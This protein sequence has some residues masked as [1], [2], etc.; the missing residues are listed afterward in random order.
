MH[1]NRKHT[2][3]LLL[4]F[5]LLPFWSS[6]QSVTTV[7]P[8]EQLDIVIDQWTAKDGL[9][10]ITG[11]YVR[12]LV[13]DR[14]GF[15]WTH[16]NHS[17]VR[18]DG[19]HFKEYPVRSNFEGRVW[20]VE[21]DL[22]GNLWVVVSFEDEFSIQVFNPREERFYSLEAYLGSTAG[23]GNEF[24]KIHLKV[25]SIGKEI[26]LIND[27][28]GQIWKYDGQLR[29]I[30]EDEE[31]ELASYLPGPDGLF[32]KTPY[33]QQK[34]DSLFLVDA[35]GNP[36]Q[37]FPN[38]KKGSYH[39]ID[40]NYQLWSVDTS[41]DNQNQSLYLKEIVRP[42]GSKNT[43]AVLTAIYSG[44]MNTTF[45]N[46]SRSGYTLYGNNAKMMLLQK[47]QVII[48]DI[49]PFLTKI[50][51]HSYHSIPYSIKMIS[52]G[53]FWMTSNGAL[54][55][56]SFRKKNFTSFLKG[57]SIRHI[58]PFGE[59]QKLLINSYELPPVVIDRQQ[60][61]QQY[62]NV[63][64]EKNFYSGYK[65]GN[66]IWLGSLENTFSQYNLTTGVN[67]LHQLDTRNE[68]DLQPRALH[69]LTDST[70]LFCSD[71]GIHIYNYKNKQ[72]Q[73]LL[74]GTLAYWIH[75]DQKGDLWA[76]TGKGVYN[77]ST[78]QF[79]LDLLN[80]SPLEVKH[81]YEAP[82]GDFWLSSNQGLIHWKPFRKDYQ[83]ISTKDGLCNNTVHAAYPDQRGVL[84]LSTDNGI[85]AFDPK[86][87]RIQNFFDTDGL[88]D[89]EQNYL[90][91]CATA[92]GQLLF[93]GVSGITAFYPDNI[94]L[95]EDSLY[96]DIYIGKATFFD[97]D[98]QPLETL[99]ADSTERYVWKIPAFSRQISF[100]VAFP[101]FDGQKKVF[102]W[103]IPG[104]FNTWNDIKENEITLNGLPAGEY[105]LEVRG[106]LINNPDHVLTK[107][108]AIH[109][110]T[111]FY[112]QSWF[113][114]ACLLLLISSGWFYYKKQVKQISAAA[115]VLENLVE[116]RTKEVLQQKMLIEKQNH[117][118]EEI[119]Q[120]KNQLFNNISHEFR[121]PLSL[122]SGNSDQLLSQPNVP[123]WVQQPALNIKKH[124]TS[125]AEM[126]DEILSLQRIDEGV[127]SL[128][129]EAMDWTKLIKQQFSLF[130][131]LAQ[132][133]QLI[134]QLEIVPDQACIVAIN[135]K[136]VTRILQNLISNAIKYTPDR[137]QIVVRT[138]IAED[139]LLFCVKDN[140]PGVLKEEQEAIFKRFYQGQAAKG[141]AQ[142]GYGIGL[143]LCAEYAK[144]MDAKLWVES[145]PD[146][147][148]TFFFRLAKEEV[149]PATTTA[150][151]TPVSIPAHKA[152][153]VTQP[154]AA[155][156]TD[157]KTAHVLIVEDN[158]ELLTFLSNQLGKHYQ[159]T[160]LTNGQL[161]LD[162][163]LEH[164]DIDLVLSDVMM[165]VRDGKSLLKEVRKE[166][167]LASIPFI[168][169]TA[170]SDLPDKIEAFQLGV[171][172]YLSKPF[173]L[174]ELF[175]RVA[176]LIHFGKARKTYWEDKVLPDAP[177]EELS[178]EH[179]VSY[180]EEWM[181]TFNALVEKELRNADLKIA[182]LAYRLH[183]SERTLR[184]R[185]M[186]YTGM[187]PSEYI[188]K[189][190]LDIAYPLVKQHKYPTIAEVA[191]AC[192]FKSARYF[193]KQFKKEF[194]K[195][196]AEY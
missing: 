89:N 21:E 163:L 150:V 31:T 47:D 196:P 1:L 180:D 193:S 137:G 92:D 192:G 113:W 95:F 156:K 152:P 127:F 175:A 164:Q 7:L 153:P 183:I 50:G 46:S 56:I 74:E 51:A 176:N 170:L 20:N 149:D 173:D 35:K 17:L 187:S 24:L 146:K 54:F 147:G 69:F 100:D 107:Q 144:L 66:Y 82:N 181:G 118:L 112:Q 135:Q 70:F 143:A 13:Q 96:Y 134:Y 109:K 53:S 186:E 88:T 63:N 171:D 86:T 68:L 97:D 85:A 94:P 106:Y 37:A 128:Q 161:A 167:A 172:S 79:Y 108:I 166:P 55:K 114:I 40:A 4:L 16:S 160:S 90:A 28:E 102:Q 191:Y 60:Y 124:T 151:A 195:S 81:I 23:P 78:Q 45:Y 91:H 174:E 98:Q 145:Q 136:K 141:N 103:R 12:K 8:H 11:S 178:E 49:W 73:Q 132:K 140:G 105:Q 38:R 131:G 76:G 10:F 33:F 155:I 26:F 59:A 5:C 188:T 138:E 27:Y 71:I 3:P 32:W 158:E 22:S 110:C 157:H 111:F 58:S 83:Q 119:N 48:D 77:L 179:I 162:F 159:V 84:W 99:V 19:K 126:L 189:N 194:G 14:R 185:I 34:Q 2:Q 154:P 165:P 52:D 148:A 184:N 61:K 121:T 25:F 116:E 29:Q 115:K 6:G 177:D 123:N 9:P 75:E 65:E 142:P 93:G 101:T 72:L 18:F 64:G 130:N 104:I 87:N 117:H 42:V 57:Y 129:T 62:L 120:A 36:V 168:M 15:I 39:S 139:E 182:D 44:P 41:F 190:R 169:L 122:I 30:F 133:K 43:S 80:N 125:L 67:L